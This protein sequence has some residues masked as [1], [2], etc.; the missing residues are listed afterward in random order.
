MII[1]D[2]GVTNHT[3]ESRNESKLNNMAKNKTHVKQENMQK[4]R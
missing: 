3:F 1:A 4:W 2:T